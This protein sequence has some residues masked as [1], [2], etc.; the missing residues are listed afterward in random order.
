[1]KETDPVVPEV[2]NVHFLRI[3]WTSSRIGEGVETGTA[4]VGMYQ[5]TNHRAHQVVGSTVG[6]S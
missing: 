4:Q 6:H 5:E 2:A 1:M 3:V